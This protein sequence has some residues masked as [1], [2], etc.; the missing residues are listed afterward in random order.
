MHSIVTHFY[1]LSVVKGITYIHP[2][3]KGAEA[4]NIF[5]MNIYLVYSLGNYTKHVSLLFHW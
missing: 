2:V 5:A 1:I 4:I 3:H